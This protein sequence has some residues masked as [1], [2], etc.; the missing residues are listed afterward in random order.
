[1]RQPGT[2]KIV[3]DIPIGLDCADAINNFSGLI[4][5][6]RYLGQAVEVALGCA[7]ITSAICGSVNLIL[8]VGF[9]TADPQRLPLSRQP[10]GHQPFLGIAASV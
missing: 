5:F 9:I 10:D 2:N 1:M 3:I 6:K 7:R 4:E 8:V